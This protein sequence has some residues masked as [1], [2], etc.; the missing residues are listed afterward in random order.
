MRETFLDKKD[1][2]NSI[3]KKKILRLCIERGE[4]SIAALSDEINASVPTVT[5]LIGELMDEGFMV[6]LG[7]SGTS[8]GR[9]PSIY[10]LNPNA[11]YFV[12]V[13]IRNSHAGAAITD[14]Q[15]NLIA[16]EDNIPFV[17]ERKEE[18]V[19]AISRAV[20]NYVE[21]R[22]LDWD[23]ILGMG[24]SLAG[25]INRETGYSN[26]YSFDPNRPINK[27]LAED[28]DIP[29]V[30][31]NDSRAMAYGEFLSGVVR[32]ERNVLFVNVSWGLGMGMILDGRLYYG[33]SG[34]AGEFGHFPLLQ[35]D[36]ICRCGKVGCLETGASGSAL[37]RMITQQLRSG[38]PS[39]LLKKF[40]TEGKININDIFMAISEE[41]VLAIDALGE[42][43]E[44]LGRG[45][46]GLINMFN[47]ELVVIGGKLAIAGDYLML[48]VQ[49]TVKKLAQNIAI[50]DT[51]IKFSRLKNQAAPIGDC[52]LSRSHL[53]GIF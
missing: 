22:H 45:L 25:R 30:I 31:E 24:I 13:D 1:S 39:S 8:G 27:I 36:E 20:R 28:L 34:Y 23:R 17:M 2:K 32:K 53:L 14:F 52:M 38:K 19:H 40:R 51:A 5:K 49:T 4:Q 3:L 21:M 46:A 11:G 43:G 16:F 10:G 26:N 35:N 15:G 42:I 47:P 9:R 12:G 29:V 50:Q 7:K 37:V 33:T 6:D 18:S 41:D 48:P 44:N